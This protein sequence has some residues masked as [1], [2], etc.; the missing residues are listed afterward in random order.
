MSKRSP[1]KHRRTL[2]AL[3]FAGVSFSMASGACAVIGQANANTPPQQ[4]HEIFLSEEEISD[5][6]LATFH[7]FDKEN[8]S[9]LRLARGGGGCGHGGGCGGHGGGC[10]GHGGGCGGC[11]MG[12]CHMGG[13]CG[14][15][16]VGCAGGCRIGGCHFG[17]CHGGCR[18]RFF[19]GG[20]HGGCRGCGGCG[21]CGGTCWIWTPG[22]WIYSCGVESLPASRVAKQ[23]EQTAE[24]AKTVDGRG[25]GSRKLSDD[26]ASGHRP[27]RSR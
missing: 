13:G 1:K 17:G 2:P 18:G 22:G 14:G 8:S 3:G 10:G 11:H 23:I 21:G 7:V 6:S 5:V 24:A 15:C 26:V 25:S 4:T 27:G 9:P 12:G 16:H 20:C 19:F